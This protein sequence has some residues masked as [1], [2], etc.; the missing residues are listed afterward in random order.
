MAATLIIGE[1]CGLNSE[2]LSDDFEPHT[3]GGTPD[4]SLQCDWRPSYIWGLRKPRGPLASS[5]HL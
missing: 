4:A 5:K 2:A 3:D 1:P